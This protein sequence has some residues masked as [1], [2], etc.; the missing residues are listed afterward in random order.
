MMASSMVNWMRILGT[1]QWLL[2]VTGSAVLV[3]L[4]GVVQLVVQIPALLWGGALADRMDRKR[5]MLVSYGVTAASLVGLGLLDRSG[6]LTPA[7][8]YAGIAVSAAAHMLASPARS[9]L[10]PIVI[11]ER[12]LLIATSTD[13]AS[14]NAA[15]I[16]G[17]LLFAAVA[18]SLGLDAVFLIAGGLAFVAAALPPTMRAA[19]VADGGNKPVKGSATWPSIPSCRVSFSSTS[20]SPRPPSTGRYCPYWRW[21]CLPAAPPP[22]AC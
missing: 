16:I 17:P 1:S 10:I 15:A 7:M 11:P 19:G 4:I 3:G 12:H 6:A 13:T 21:D 18:V 5:L 22:P 9:A 14:A 2:D 8:V 20:V